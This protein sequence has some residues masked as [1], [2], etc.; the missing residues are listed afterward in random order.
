MMGKILPE[1]CWA[2]LVDQYITVASSWFICI[3]LPNYFVSQWSFWQPQ[4][5]TRHRFLRSLMRNMSNTEATNC[6][7]SVTISAKF[8]QKE[9][10]IKRNCIFKKMFPAIRIQ[11]KQCKKSALYTICCMGKP[12][13]GKD[14]NLTANSLL[15]LVVLQPTSGLGRQTHTHTH[16][17]RGEVLWTRNQ[18][19]VAATT[20]TTHK[21]H[22]NRTSMLSVAF[23]PAMPAIKRLKIDALNSMAIGVCNGLLTGQN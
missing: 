4:Y 10:P 6:R 2:D 3:T 11:R 19:T 18:P 22:K 17:Q 21:T 16:T 8:A 5:K 12:N 9:A 20:Y 13:T 7:L 1:T 14:G 23:E 15:S